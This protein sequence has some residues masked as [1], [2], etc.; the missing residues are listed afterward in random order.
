MKVPIAIV[1]KLRWCGFTL[2]L[3]SV[4]ILT[5]F[6]IHYIQALGWSLSV[7]SCGVWVFDSYRSKHKPRMFME[8][9]YMGFGIWGIINW[10]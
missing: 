9:M 2:A 7:I 1:R 5:T 3:F 4:I 10:L 6:K 8:L